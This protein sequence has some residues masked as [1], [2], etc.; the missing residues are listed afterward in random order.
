MKLLWAEVSNP[1]WSG[2]RCLGALAEMEGPR[3]WRMGVEEKKT[4]W[5]SQAG[6][7]PRGRGKRP[8]EQT[9]F[10]GRLGVVDH[11]CFGEGGVDNSHRGVV[12]SSGTAWRW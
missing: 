7:S 9:A 6:A 11:V 1:L 2:P 8:G 3:G 4:P 5:T 10:E 12:R